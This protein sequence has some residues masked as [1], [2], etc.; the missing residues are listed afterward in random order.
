MKLPDMPRSHTAKFTVIISAGLNFFFRFE[1][2]KMTYPFPRVERIPTIMKKRKTIKLEFSSKPSI[3]H[4]LCEI[5]WYFQSELVVL[6]LGILLWNWSFHPRYAADRD[7]YCR[8]LPP[9]T[10]AIFPSAAEHSLHHLSLHNY[11]LN[12]HN[13]NPIIPAFWSIPFSHKHLYIHKNG[14]HLYA[15]TRTPIS[16]QP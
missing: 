1:D 6:K 12:V 2:I 7:I 14:I 10:N 4:L 15:I 11:W 16:D 5:P 3:F 8:H 9:T 13:R